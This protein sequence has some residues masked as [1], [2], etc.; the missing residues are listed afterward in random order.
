M[1][2]LLRTTIATIITLIV[3][4][5]LYAQDLKGVYM[6]TEEKEGKIITHE[7]KF[8]DTYSMHTVYEAE[9]PQ[10]I[11]TLGGFYT[12]EGDSLL[13]ELEFNSDYA[14]DS[15]SSK[16]MAIQIEDDKLI[17]NG[18]TNRIYTRLV[19]KDQDLDGAW[20]FGTR[21]PDEGQ[22]RRG[23]SRDRKTL[24][25]LKDSRFQ[26]IAYTIGSFRFSGTGGGKFT[27]ENGIY[28]EYIEFFSRDN[29]RVGAELK[30]TYDLQG[31]DWHHKGKNSRGEP[32][33]EIWMQRQR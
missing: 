9:P 31:D 19:N 6:A 26:W 33:Y 27:S 24:K 4:M 7:I 12:T 22:E 14:K 5:P 16:R 30:F 18:N 20:L 15:I 8:S 25:F 11:K 13:V 3:N 23:D 10:F 2:T 28:T 29:S 17:I 21:G 32:M 1:S